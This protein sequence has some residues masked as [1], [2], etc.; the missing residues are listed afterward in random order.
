MTLWLH[1]PFTITPQLE[2]NCWSS[3]ISVADKNR[4]SRLGWP[5]EPVG[6]VG[7]GRMEAKLSSLLEN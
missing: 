7:D 5:L 4:L 2:S 1:Q 6:L 3:R